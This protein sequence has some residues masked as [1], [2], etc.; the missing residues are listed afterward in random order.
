MSVSNIVL[1]G[2]PGAGKTTVLELLKTFPRKDN[3]HLIFL[4]EVAS[5]ILKTFPRIHKVSPEIFQATILGTQLAVSQIVE[6]GFDNAI[7]ISDRGIYDL[8]AYIDDQDKFCEITGFPP[9]LSLPTYDLVIYLESLDSFVGL[10]NNLY[11]KEESIHQVKEVEAKTRQAW[12]SRVVA[13]EFVVVPTCNLIQD[14]ARLVAEAINKHLGREV[15]DFE[16]GEVTNES[17]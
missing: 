14:K 17:D 8:W 7:C 2:G 5:T 16:K 11:R 12:E 3:A 9:Y 10:A 6:R 4:D 13:R 15:F 1:A